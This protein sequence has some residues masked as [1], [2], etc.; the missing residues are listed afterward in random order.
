MESGG[1]GVCECKLPSPLHLPQLQD[2][3]QSPKPLHVNS[4]L[5]PK[6]TGC[7]DGHRP[8]EGGLQTPTVRDQAGHR[9][10]HPLRA[11]VDTGGQRN[12]CSSL[13]SATGSPPGRKIY[14]AQI[15]HFPPRRHGLTPSP[16]PWEL[17]P[18][19]PPQ[20]QSLNAVR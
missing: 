8:G 6:H 14:H 10:H 5:S 1:S 15:L 20:G 11:S 7:Q 3:A 9:Q 13:P 12:G 4:C 19:T 17:T 16:P 2:E 18:S